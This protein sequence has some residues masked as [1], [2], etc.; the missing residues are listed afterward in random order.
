[1]LHNRQA[2]GRDFHEHCSK[3]AL[4]HTGKS[5]IRVLLFGD[6]KNAAA[7]GPSPCDLGCILLGLWLSKEKPQYY[8][9]RPPK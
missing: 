9:T 6:D 4:L 5:T 1:M 2:P 3:P 7:A 8:F